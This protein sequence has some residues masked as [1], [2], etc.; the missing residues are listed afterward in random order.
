MAVGVTSSG[1][2]NS[3]FNITDEKKTFSITIPG[4]WNSKLAEIFID[5]LNRILELRSPKD[6]ELHVEQ[7]RKKWNKFN[8]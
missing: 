8:D 3:V 7:F 2:I 1:G 5:E 4:H 6:I